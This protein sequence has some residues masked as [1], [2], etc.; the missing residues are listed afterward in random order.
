VRAERDAT[1]QRSI[2]K[3]LA[4][5]GGRRAACGGKLR[6]HLTYANIGVTLLFI[7][8]TTGLA[9]AASSSSN[10]V[11]SGCYLK[12]KGTLR[13]I[14]GKQK[15]DK[16]SE[17]A[18][19]WNQQGVP[20]TRGTPGTPGIAGVQGSQGPAGIPGIPGTTG[21]AGTPGT[22]GTNGTNGTNATVLFVSM[23]SNGP[24]IDAS[25]VETINHTPSTGAYDITFGQDISHCV[26]LATIGVRNGGVPGDPEVSANSPAGHPN[27]HVIV[28]TSVGSTP[29][30]RSFNLAVFC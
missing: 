2:A 13:V 19:S 30:D 1:T 22:P 26:Y 6:T 25:G 18:L 11:I 16:R 8:G 5:R 27:T 3:A 7:M 15:C 28:N 12:S 23:N 4:R 9:V 10:A 29:T 24:T 14:K 20:G 17:V 21:N